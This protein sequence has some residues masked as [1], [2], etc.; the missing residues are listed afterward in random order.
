MRLRLDM[1]INRRRLRV[2]TAAAM[3]TAAPAF[4]LD[5]P[6]RKDG[7]CIESKDPRFD[8][9]GTRRFLEGGFRAP[10]NRRLD[11]I[12]GR[13]E[14]IYDRLVSILAEPRAVV[15]M[16][17]YYGPEP[18]KMFLEAARTLSAAP[19]AMAAVLN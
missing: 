18:R 16:G 6:T 17:D 13:L 9:E 19:A 12:R 1:L 14:A 3:L 8:R 10:R 5:L 7:L 15:Q 2:V 4:A 11:R